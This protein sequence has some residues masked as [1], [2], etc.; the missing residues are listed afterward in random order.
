M[1]IGKPK[2]ING[3]RDEQVGI[4]SG[5]ESVTLTCKVTG[6]DIIGGYWERL[7]SGPLP[8]KANM[9]SLNN[10]KTRLKLTIVGV[11]PKYSGMYHCVM[12]SQWGVV[13]SRNIQVTITSES[14]NVLM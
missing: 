3:P 11:H 12:Y 14:N 8:N 4:V 1:Y 2:I 7:G 9:S 13:Q 5:N 6:D 10:D